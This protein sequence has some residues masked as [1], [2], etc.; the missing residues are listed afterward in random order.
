[1]LVSNGHGPPS[2][3]EHDGVGSFRHIA[4]V[5][6]ASTSK[7]ACSSVDALSLDDFMLRLRIKEP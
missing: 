7:F 2:I 1:M 5:L 4:R 6:R 3:K